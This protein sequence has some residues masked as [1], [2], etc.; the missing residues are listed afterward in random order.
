MVPEQDIKA[1]FSIIDTQGGREVIVSKWEDEMLEYLAACHIKDHNKIEA[2][3][4][5]ARKA[6][7]ENF[8]IL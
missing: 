7:T 2:I 4:D 8:P 1:L 5:F 3:S 6:K